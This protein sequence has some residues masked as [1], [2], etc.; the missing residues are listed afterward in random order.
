MQN[1]LEATILIYVMIVNT[2][3]SIHIVVIHCIS[4]SSVY[5][6]HKTEE[7]EKARKCPYNRL[8]RALKN[9]QTL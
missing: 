3:H 9:I 1:I 6:N 5:K 7:T 4:I 8:L 2:D